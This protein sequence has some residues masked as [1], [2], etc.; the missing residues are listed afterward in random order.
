MNDEVNRVGPNRDEELQ[1]A[2]RFIRRRLGLLI[3]SNYVLA[4]ALTITVAVVFGNLVDYHA[5]DPL[6][7]G[8]CL[9]GA[10]A[11]GFVF[12]WIAGRRS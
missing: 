12:G 9:A 6:M 5:A 10:A 8:G 11:L 7:Y 2:I 1:E 3:V 4:L